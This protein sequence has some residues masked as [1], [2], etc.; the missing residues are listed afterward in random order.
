MA[1]AIITDLIFI[2]FLRAEQK[3]GRAPAHP[4]EAPPSAREECHED[5][6]IGAPRRQ[7]F[8][9]QNLAVFYGLPADAKFVLLCGKP[10]PAVSGQSMPIM[11]LR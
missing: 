6:P 8:T 3:Q 7:D 5:A 2:F 4:V 1:E 11:A 10:A 9:F